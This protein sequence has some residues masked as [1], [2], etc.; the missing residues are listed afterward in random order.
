MSGCLFFSSPLLSRFYL[1]GPKMSFLT[2]SSL[3]SH[4][5]KQQLP[6]AVAGGVCPCGA[7]CLALLAAPPAPPHTVSSCRQ[8]RFPPVSGSRLGLQWCTIIALGWNS[9]TGR[10]SSELLNR[11]PEKLATWQS[12]FLSHSRERHLTNTCLSRPKCISK[13]RTD[14]IISFQ[15]RGRGKKKYSMHQALSICQHR[16]CCFSVL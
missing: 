8:D 5:L 1:E 7:F 16:F 6:G 3:G 4:R 13:N 9:A 15:R 14:K 12:D 11:L 2:E 10:Q